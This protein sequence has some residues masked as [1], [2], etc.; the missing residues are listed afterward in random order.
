MGSYLIE[1]STS[2]LNG[3]KLDVYR[4]VPAEI[5]KT[6]E[7]MRAQFCGEAINY[8]V[9]RDHKNETFQQEVI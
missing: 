2:S 3:E 7:Y 1:E 5:L 9:H 4:F 8:K 6:S